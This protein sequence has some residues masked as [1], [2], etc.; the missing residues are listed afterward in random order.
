MTSICCYFRALTDAEKCIIL[1]PEWAKGYF[2]KGRALAGLKVK[3]PLANSKYSDT[4]ILTCFTLIPCIM[5]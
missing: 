5:L 1:N 4:T 3:T 2:R